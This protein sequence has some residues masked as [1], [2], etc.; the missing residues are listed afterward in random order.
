[1]TA[2]PTHPGP[3]EALVRARLARF[4]ATHASRRLWDGDVTF[5]KEDPSTPEVR[6][7]L[8]WLRVGATMAPHLPVLRALAES[9]RGAFERILLCGMGGSSLAPEVLW[10]SFGARPGFPRFDLLDSTDPRAVQAAT[11]ASPL[12]R[13]LVLVAS[14]SGGT[15]ETDAMLRH[16]WERMP[17]GDHFVAITDP[18]TGLARLATERRFRHVFLNPPDIGGRYSALSLFGLVPAALAGIDVG[19]LLERGARMAAACGPEVPV[20]SHPGL[21]LGAVLGEAALQGRDKLTLVLDPEIGC[22]GAWVEQLVAESTGKEGRGILP[23]V[24]EPLGDPEVY[25][26]DRIFVSLERAGRP[27]AWEDRLAAL[28]AAGHPIVR[29]T[30]EEPLD[31]GAEFFRWEFATAVAGAVLGINPFD[32]PNVAESKRNTQQVLAGA[33]PLAPASSPEAAAELLRAVRTGDYLA[34]LAYL[35]P[36]AQ[37][38]ARLAAVRRR[39][40]DRLRVATTVGYGPRYLHSTGQ[41]HKGGP[42]R[43]RFLLVTSRPERDVPIPGGQHGFATVQAAQAEGDLRA[44]HARGLPVV[45]LEDLDALEQL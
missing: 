35:P 24:D 9:A 7:R 20:E 36:T 23:V 26:E 8:G 43:G 39:L 12:D 19:A 16:F 18:G 42:P 37:H 10:R 38:D 25:G 32:Q 41:L 5:W 15:L 17:H 11:E 33:E 1:V 29:S 4:D 13:T 22:F 14:K 21:L 44:L 27:P 3:L 31:L 2:A 34:I 6:D 45:R 30:Y 40:R 28:A